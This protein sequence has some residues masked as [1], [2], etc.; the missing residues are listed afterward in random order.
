MDIAGTP[1]YIAPEVL[2]GVYGI[3]CDIWSLG[4]SLFQILTGQ[5]PFKG[6]TQQEVFR[7]IKSGK[8]DIPSS[9]SK[10]CADL[11]MNM[12]KVNPK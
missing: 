8:F 7:K 5:L 4:V 11:I 3:Q 1:Y 9:L 12:I 6:N 2:D 10:D